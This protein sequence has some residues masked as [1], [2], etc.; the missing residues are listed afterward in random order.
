M[1]L[2]KNSID[3]LRKRIYYD[4]QIMKLHRRHTKMYR[5]CP[6]MPEIRRV[7]ETGDHRRPEGKKEKPPRER[8]LEDKA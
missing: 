5:N 3:K 8:R 2:R 7:L 6:E 4:K 1:N